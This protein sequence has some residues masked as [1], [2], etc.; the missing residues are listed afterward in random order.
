MKKVFLN[1]LTAKQII[2]LIQKFLNN[3]NID[4][5]YVGEYLIIYPK[6]FLKI[7]L[8]KN[9][10]KISYVTFLKTII[11][12]DYLNEQ[13]EVID[14]EFDPY[15]VFDFNFKTIQD[16]ESKLLEIHNKDNSKLYFT[17][18]ELIIK[19]GKRIERIENLK[20]REKLQNEFNLELKKLRI[21]EEEFFSIMEKYI[22]F[23]SIKI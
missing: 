1:T 16:I 4:H 19:E 2:T 22:N 6:D 3:N 8:Q 14:I 7:N 20:K 12:D 17:E 23:T 13:S 18:N 5:K 11:E 9:S 15:E 21:S 10:N